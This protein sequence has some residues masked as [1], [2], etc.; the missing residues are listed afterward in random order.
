MVRLIILIALIFSKSAF[1]QLPLFDQNEV[2]IIRLYVQNADSI[3][4][5]YKGNNVDYHLAKF[6][7]SNGVQSD[8][9]DSIG[10]RI[11][12]NTSLQSKKKSF[13]ISFNKY[14]PNRDYKGVK[15]LNLIGYHNDPTYVR[16]KLFYECYTKAGL[17]SRRSSFVHFY[18]NNTYFGLMGNMEEIDKEWLRDKFGYDEGNLY[19]CYYGSNLL[20]TTNNPNDYKF[21]GSQRVYEL[22][23]NQ[24]A[25]NYTDLKNLIK[26]INTNPTNTNYLT[27]LDTIFDYQE[28]L[29]IYALDILTGN[30]DDYAY[31]TNNYYLYNDSISGKFHFITFDTDNTFGIDWFNE[32]WALRKPIGWEHP[33]N[34]RP[35]VKNILSFPIA[36]NRFLFLVDSMRKTITN[37]DSIFSKIDSLQSLLQPYVAADSFKKL[38]YGYTLNSFNQGFVGSNGGHAK[39]GIKPFLQIRFQS[40]EATPLQSELN[41]VEAIIYPN[42]TAHKLSFQLNHKMDG[43][44]LIYDQN[45]KIML[46]QKINDSVE[47]DVSKFSSG[48]Y[49]AVFR[50]KNGKQN[51]WLFIKE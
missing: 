50:D 4:A 20:Y 51:S 42:P 2:H 6:V 12:G 23:T 45:G 18:I 38:D 37:P 29:K 31:N 3:N 44:V 34:P 19:K 40:L 22:A 36:R 46:E 48:T 30:W 25:D 21:G 15:K 5:I 49:M 32:N 35:L 27:Y 11:R 24:T 16:E 14:T 26:T 47:F 28:Y 7:Y 17:P 43:T 13:K 10:V 41:N 1:A 9:L 33:T 8:T 39:I